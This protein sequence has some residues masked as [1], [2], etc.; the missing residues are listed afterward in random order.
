MMSEGPLLRGSSMA[1]LDVPE[2]REEGIGAMG[3]RYRSFGDDDS[4]GLDS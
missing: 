4:S 3:M 2:V 1:N